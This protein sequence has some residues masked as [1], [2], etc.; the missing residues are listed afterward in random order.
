MDVNELIFQDSIIYNPTGSIQKVY[1]FSIN[2]G[3][4]L[5]LTWIYEFD[6]DSGNKVTQKSTYLVPTKEYTSIEK[7]YWNKNNI[8]RT[9]HYN[10][11]G[12][13]HYE[14]F[15]TYDNKVNYKKGLPLSI[16]DPVSWS[17]NN[18][19]AMN[20][21]D[22]Y[23]NLDLICRPCVATYKYNLDHYPVEIKY[24]WGRTL[25]LTYE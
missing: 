24:N 16:T 11:K 10:G 7:Y 23:G 5:A 19:T 25:K 2:A 21:K 9:D 4:D 8:E 13:L 12:E 3:E 1:N 20:W 18:V 14:Y 22:Y 17:E 15:Y 6:Y